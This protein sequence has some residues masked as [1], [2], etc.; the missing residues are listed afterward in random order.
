[1]EHQ[2]ERT[3]YRRSL[4]LGLHR[5]TQ[6][7]GSQ[8]P[9]KLDQPLA[10]RPSAKRRRCLSP[11]RLFTILFGAPV[12]DT[13]C[14]IA[15]VEELADRSLRKESDSPRDL[16]RQLVEVFHARQ[17]RGRHGRSG[18]SFSV[19]RSSGD[20]SHVRRVPYPHQRP[21][22]NRR[23]MESPPRTARQPL[24]R[25]SRRLRRRS[26]EAGCVVVRSRSTICTKARASQP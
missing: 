8:N 11:K 19:R 23:R 3:G 9:P 10:R 26:F 12:A 4:P 21:R 16:R 17:A 6:L 1:M 24:A 20:A 13:G 14:S 2:P 5:P 15:A 7:R 25:L 18:L 22:P